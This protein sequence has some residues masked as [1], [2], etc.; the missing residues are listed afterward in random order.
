MIARQFAKARGVFRSLR[1]I[2]D[3]V[4]PGAFPLVGFAVERP[5]FFP[6]HVGQ[7]ARR[8]AR[9]QANKEFAVLGAA[10]FLAEA[11][12]VARG[13][14]AHGDAAAVDADEV[15]EERPLE[16]RRRQLHVG[17]E[18]G[19]I[20]IPDL[21]DRRRQRADDVRFRIHDLQHA[22]Q[23]LRPVRIVRIEKGDDRRARRRK[24]KIT[25]GADAAIALRRNDLKARIGLRREPGLRAVARAVVDHDQLE[26]RL[27]LR[28]HA[29]DRARQHVEAV[30]ARD[31][32][33]TPQRQDSNVFGHWTG[34]INIPLVGCTAYSP[35]GLNRPAFAGLAGG[36]NSMFSAVMP[37]GLISVIVTTYNR[38][39][40]LDAVLRSLARQNDS[41][42][43][44]DRGRRRLA[45]R[46]RGDGRSLE[47]QGRPPPRPCLARRPRLPR[48]RNPQPRHPR[49]ARRLLHLPRRRLHRAAGFRRHASASRRTRLLRHRQPHSAVAGADGQSAAR[50]AHAGDL[51]RGA[52]ARA[53][54]C[55]AAS[56]GCRRCCICRSGRCAGCAETPGAARAPAISPSGAPISIASTASTATTAAGARRIPT[57]SCGCCMPA[58]R[59]RTASSPPASCICGTPIT[60]AT[61]SSR[62]NASCRTVS[63]SDRVRARRGLSAL[64]G[65]PSPALAG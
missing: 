7:Q 55:A 44:G 23:P 39:D 46:N 53:N 63:P 35:Q 31:D 13:L 30:K 42:F 40:A 61:G 6:Q 51:D 28:Q 29:F 27:V 14:R 19:A 20:F 24:A 21:L 45:C 58:S 10:Q 57:S 41:G 49:L 47:R 26:V 64:Q 32:D 37:S 52:L 9:R 36:A 18:I 15:A 4:A 3:E 2:G 33:G 17:H 38:E 34:K 56:T 16:R 11:A 25:R 50:Q 5:G 12:D 65:A 62:T 43:R 54:A 8:A 59:A 1:E 48:R 22:A 60:D